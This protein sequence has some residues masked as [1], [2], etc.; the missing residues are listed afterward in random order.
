MLKEVFCAVC[1]SKD[2]RMKYPE[3][4]NYAGIDFSPRRRPSKNHCRI[5]QCNKCG[6]IYA[7]PIL[8]DDYILQ[9][10]RDSTFINE[11]QVELMA[12]DYLDQLK[13]AG[14]LMDNK[15]NLLE[16]GCGNGC[17]LKK[18]KEFGF[19]NVY[20]VEPCKNSVEQADQEVK[21]NIVNDVFYEGLYKDNFFDL[22]CVIQVFD[23]LIDPND[24]LRNIYRVTKEDGYI[25]VISH[26]VKFIL[27]K[28]LG[29]KSPMYDI[30][31]IYLFD[32][33][34]IRKLL[35][36][37]GFQV[38][39]VEDIMSRYTISHVLKMFPLPGFIK[40]F[41]M[42]VTSRLGIADKRIKI[43]GGNMVALAK[44]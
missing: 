43:M 2:Y 42:N 23:H 7:D 20:G 29:E 28:I 37:H 36:K 16:I 39:Y 3:C 32:K 10:Y 30:E 17:F 40:N 24:V 44:K 14:S 11:I 6:L 18:A 9:L 38:I 35:E 13:R 5:V 26:N 19:K 21:R 4:I 22:V 1:Q 27:T 41:L 12:E 25:L 8:N 15:D 31:H 33:I 34:T